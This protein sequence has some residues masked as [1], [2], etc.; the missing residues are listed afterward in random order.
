MNGS[1]E[2]FQASSTALA[3]ETRRHVAEAQEKSVDAIAAI[4]ARV[5]ATLEEG[6][7]DAMAAIRKQVEEFS[8]ALQTSSASLG[9]QARAIARLR[10]ARERR[11]KSLA[12]RRSYP[13]S[14]RA[15][16]PFQREDRGDDQA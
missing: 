12:S 16:D 11:R 14:G 2:G 4:S 8:S 10:S 9:Q 1:L 3:D 15:G 6:L 5:A 7:A 13:R